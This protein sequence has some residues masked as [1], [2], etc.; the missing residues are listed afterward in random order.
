[1]SGN[2][3]IETGRF[4]KSRVVSLICNFGG[5]EASQNK[6]WLSVLEDS[7]SELHGEYGSS[8]VSECLRC[9]EVLL[10]QPFR[11]PV[12]FLQLSQCKTLWILKGCFQ[13]HRAWATSSNSECIKL[14]DFESLR[15]LVASVWMITSWSSWIG[16]HA[17]MQEQ[18]GYFDS[19]NCLFW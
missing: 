1:V 12:K 3:E 15:E 7:G 14:I 19:E 18:S 8:R 11:L 2:L 16:G 4:D 13:T 5:G 9:F 10:W 17:P 6:S